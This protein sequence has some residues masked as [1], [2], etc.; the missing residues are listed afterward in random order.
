[1]DNNQIANDSFKPMP[2][3]LGP[4]DQFVMIDSLFRH[5]TVYSQIENI[6]FKPIA[7]TTDTLIMLLWRNQKP[8]QYPISLDFLLNLFLTSMM[9]MIIMMGG[10]YPYPLPTA[11][12]MQT[13][14]NLGVGT[15]LIFQTNI[16][17]G[18]KLVLD[19]TRVYCTHMQV[20]RDDVFH[21][22]T[23]SISKFIWICSEPT[24]SILEFICFCRESISI[25]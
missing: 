21:E 16:V 8:I 18:V 24:E 22:P 1:M 4:I 13:T 15:S 6:N 10:P 25:S 12:P 20:Y 14:L 5:Y 2:K 9:I 19:T 7:C 3:D 23:E 17:Y 11:K